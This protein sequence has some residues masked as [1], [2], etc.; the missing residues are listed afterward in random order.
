MYLCLIQVQ[1]NKHLRAQ[2]S[3]KQS[4]LD[5][6][7]E[8]MALSRRAHIRWET[9]YKTRLKNL[10]EEK[11]SWGSEKDNVKASLAEGKLVVGRQGEELEMLGSRCV[12]MIF[13]SGLAETMI[14]Y[15]TWK[16]RS[17]MRNQKLQS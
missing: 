8:E 3:E 7:R 11:R 17:R 16:R 13:L 1:F 5:K 12:S 14:G 15:L 10:K 9:E 2:L 4:A 6:V